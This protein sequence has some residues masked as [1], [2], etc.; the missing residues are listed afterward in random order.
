M[1]VL[2]AVPLDDVDVNVP[3]TQDTPQDRS[4]SRSDQAEALVDLA[5]GRREPLEQR[6]AYF[7]NRLHQASDDY[8]ATEG[9][10]VVEADL[11]LVPRHGER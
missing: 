8:A 6:L 2:T 10:R 3:G 4:F 9:L 5:G 11:R 7:Q 1:P